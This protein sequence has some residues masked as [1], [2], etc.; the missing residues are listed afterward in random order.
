MVQIVAAR[1]VVL[2]AHGTADPKDLLTLGAVRDAVQDRLGVVVAL[3]FVDVAT[4]TLAEVLAAAPGALVVPLF[5]TGGYHVEVDLPAAAPTRASVIVTDHLGA[6]AALAPALLAR[7]R[8]AHPAPQT[9]VLLAAGSSRATARA[10]IDDLAAQLARLAG[11]PVTVGF[12]TGPGPT[13]SDALAQVQHAADAVAV[14]ALLAPGLFA[15]RAAQLAQLHGIRVARVLGAEPT[16]V[17]VI[18]GLVAPRLQRLAAAA[19]APPSQAAD[20]VR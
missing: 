10:E 13:A 1:P 19:P 3:G 5:V 11:V 6:G 17:D 8:E 18:A 14:P 9:V 12:L 20:D 2:A 4:P 7:A 15:T 16:V